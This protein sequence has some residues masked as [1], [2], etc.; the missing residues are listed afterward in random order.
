M[1]VTSSGSTSNMA[2]RISEGK[3]KKG[4]KDSS[5]I[6]NG[7]DTKQESQSTSNKVDAKESSTITNDNG[8]IVVVLTYRT[9]EVEEDHALTRMVEDLRKML[10]SEESDDAKEEPNIAFIMNELTVA[11]LTVDQVNHMLVEL[12]TRQFD[13]TRELAHA[14]HQKS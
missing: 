1:S 10:P 6:L 12:L 4:S 8:A 13:E 9:N 3:S 7:S 2:D 5:N 14:V 11:P